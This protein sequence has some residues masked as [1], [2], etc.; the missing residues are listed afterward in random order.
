MFL[1]ANLFQKKINYPKSILIRL[2][3][4]CTLKCKICLNQDDRKKKMIEDDINISLFKDNMRD[5][6]EHK[7][8]IIL[9]GGDVFL[10]KDILKIISLLK[11]NDIPFAI[12]TNG[13]LA[14]KYTDKLA[15]SGVK[16]IYFS[17]D[18]YIEKYHD[19]SRGVRGSYKKVINSIKLLAAAC[20]KNN[21]KI[22]ITIG[23]AINKYNYKHLGR[24]YSYIN[25]MGI[26][27]SWRVYHTI[28][29]TPQAKKA[30]FSKDNT[31]DL[32]FVDGL[33]IKKSNY[34]SKNQVTVLKKQISIIL[35]ESKTSETKLSINKSVND[36]LSMYYQ[37]VFPSKKSKCSDY[38][39]STVIHGNKLLTICGYRLGTL[40]KKNTIM[41]LWK[42]K[43]SIFINKKSEN[44]ILPQCFRCIKL[45]Y[46]FE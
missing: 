38:L 1:M 15:N 7:P 41:S 27:D 3:N 4:K 21:T 39:Y 44:K 30:I 23:T 37:G 2:T 31:Q 29:I 42:N 19:Q 45:K 36:N 22:D 33:E 6:I 8:Y 32:D 13:F 18:H 20:I 43:N 34:F 10:N 5:F 11:K 46:Y 35:K 25:K 26:I 16:K 9:T 12:L 40:D 14:Y 17:L 28:F 24:F